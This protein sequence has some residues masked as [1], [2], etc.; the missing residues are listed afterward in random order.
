MKNPSVRQIR[1]F[2]LI[3]QGYSKRRAMREAGYSISSAN[4][5][6]RIMQTDSM[7]GLVETFQDKLFDAG[8]T[9]EY[10]ALK[11]AEFID[12]KKPD[13]YPDYPTQIRA[14]E[15]CL[16]IFEEAY[17]KEERKPTRTITVT[18]WVNQDN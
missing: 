1:T 5:A 13:G 10:I 6:K 9:P 3:N 17:K 15:L 16:K 14:L 18:D 12:A 7:V 8:L 4:Q 11:L 2:Q